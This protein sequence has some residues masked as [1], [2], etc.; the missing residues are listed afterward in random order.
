MCP[1]NMLA[2]NLKP[3]DIFLAKYEMN[4]IKTN[5]GNKAR[6]QPAGTKREKKTKPCFWKPNTVAPKTTVK[7]TAKVNTKWLVEA[8]LYG[9]IPIK[10]L[11]KININNVYINGKYIC[12]LLEF[13]WFVTMLCIVAYRDSWL[14]DQRLLTTLLKL[15]AKI[16]KVNAVKVPIIKYSPILVRE[17]FKLASIGAFKLNIEFISNCSRGLGIVIYKNV[18][19]SFLLLEVYI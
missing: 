6:G 2:P 8:K 12:P 15:V 16:F 17:R 13:I 14:I 18:V 19:I 7:L 3:R 10:L 4:S 11:I 5:K 9:T 1:D